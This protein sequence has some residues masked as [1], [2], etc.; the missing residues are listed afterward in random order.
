[1][2]KFLGFADDDLHRRTS[3][4]PGME[5]KEADYTLRFG[6]EK[7]LVEAE[8]LNKSLEKTRGSGIDQV[9]LWL[10]KRSFRADY[11]L[12][13]NGFRWVLL[14]YDSEE[15][16]LKKLLD[17][18][19]R[20][21]FQELFGQKHIAGLK[22]IAPKFYRG[23]SRDTILRA[24]KEKITFLEMHKE[25]IT[26]EFYEDYIRY[27]FGAEKRSDRQVHCLLNEISSAEGSSDSDKRLF[28]V[29]LMSRLIFVKF[30]EDK[31]LVGNNFLGKLFKDYDALKLPSTFYKT[32][33]QVLFYDVFNTASN[34]RKTNVQAIE[35]FRNIPYLNGGLFRESVSREKE[36]DVENDIL[37]EII[38]NLLEKYSFT[39]NGDEQ[40][41]NPD[42]LGNV[43]EKTI[44]YLTG[45]AGEN[46]RKDI[47][48]YYTP[49]EI[50][51]YISK[52]T[53]QPIILEKIKAVFKQFGWSDA[54]MAPYNTLD[55][56]IEDI[57]STNPKII[58]AI[59]DEIDKIK[60]LDPA[61]GS[62]HFLTSAMKELVFTK[63]KLLERL[64]KEASYFAIKKQ[65]INNNLYGV[66]I[67]EATVEIAKLRLWLGMIE[68]IDLSDFAHTQTLPNI[69]YKIIGGNSLIGWVDESLNQNLVITLYDER[70]KGIFET[71]KF[72]YSRNE[73]DVERFNILSESEELLSKKSGNAVNNLKKAYA[74]LQSLYAKEEGE[75][76]VR[77]REIIAAIRKSIYSVV[78]PAFQNY[79][80]SMPNSKKI[81]KNG[82]NVNGKGNGAENGNGA[83]QKLANQFHWNIDFGDIIDA[84]GF[85]IIIGNPPYG[86]NN[87]DLLRKAGYEV[88]DI[89]IAFLLRCAVL[90]RESG[91]IGFIVP[92][93]WETGERYYAFRKEIFGKLRLSRLINLP[94]NT[95]QDAYVDTG[96]T[97]FRK[98]DKL[99]RLLIYS[100][101][102]NEPTNGLEGVDKK[103]EAISYEQLV[104]DPY[105]RIFPQPFVYR[106]LNRFVNNANIVAV[107]E[108]AKSSIGIL[109]S[110]YNIN[111]RKMSRDYLPFF[112]GNVY[113][114]A[115][116]RGVIK[117]VDFSKH[118][119]NEYI[120]YYRGERILVRRIVNRQNR[121]MANLET[122]EFVTKK[123][124]YSF[125]LTTDVY[126]LRYIL[127]LL[128]S[129]LFSYLYL[130]T[131]TI[132]TKDDFRQTTL[133]ELR[134]L[135]ILK[136]KKDEQ[137]P[138]IAL[139]DRMFA[140]NKR[141][142][143]ANIAP[144]EL[145]RV[146]KEIEDA[147][148]QIDEL[149][150]KIY[151]ITGDEKKVIEVV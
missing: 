69:E 88:D 105:K 29:N 60:V 70:M 91:Y 142:H 127:S 97:I 20:G 61:C 56:F 103:L 95:F 144:Q 104:I 93:S 109:A 50:T 17:I 122:E 150:Y 114:Y 1:M 135:P 33:L 11:G 118:A 108:I 113:R 53:I 64:E 78:S 32:Y 87:I 96:I 139:A 7:I 66:D 16:K 10:E 30:L 116:Q 111:D 148:F 98:F 24:A 65:T 37:R 27:V 151:G 80:F 72:A 15:Y 25:K 34:K 68:D 45:N 140:L 147:D 92:V 3:S 22:D 58:R 39:L 94:F 143:E 100:Y 48:A 141:A 74:G 107:G 137:Q 124:L 35:L 101:P 131:S 57:G 46:K 21:F 106:I 63:K 75:G 51:A 128:N 85:D 125:K 42:I 41:L 43:F 9:G 129:R 89:Y 38:K 81:G 18:D 126:D 145:A 62:G 102:K 14:K 4:E 71:L 112:M 40:A 149:V 115:T 146:K 121:L 99:D 55:D 23:F 134:R 119:D 79:V 123:D 67:E 52:N 47:G 110:D 136:I 2:F 54:N 8:P 120:D 6:A 83:V 59:C 132:A 138:F 130:S 19:L 28:S 90:I 117:Y 26:K 5:R 13:T 31:G 36:Y 77:L 76:A 82:K 44:N 86:R 73:S 84:G 133:S 49:E 12:A